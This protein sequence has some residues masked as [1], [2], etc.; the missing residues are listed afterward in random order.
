MISFLSP[1][2]VGPIQ[3]RYFVLFG[4]NFFAWKFC[5]VQY[6]VSFVILIVFFVGIF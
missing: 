3:L 2:E 1:A 6:V 4:L 5:D